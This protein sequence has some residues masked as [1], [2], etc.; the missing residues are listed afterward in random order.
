MFSGPGRHPKPPITGKVGARRRGIIG[1]GTSTKRRR[2]RRQAL[3]GDTGQPQAHPAPSRG[4]LRAR[5]RTGGRRERRAQGRAK[6]AGAGQDQTALTA[7]L[8]PM[9]TRKAA[10]TA[11]KRASH[12]P[13]SPEAFVR[14]MSEGWVDAPITISRADQVERLSARRTELASAFA[15][16]VIVIPSGGEK[17]RSN[18]TS[19]RYR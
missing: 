6:A 18:D 14:F 12:D 7:N 16:A 2:P 10:E 3:P 1:H 11:L 8:S 4:S 19:F 17:T 15:D 13:D 9:E 5:P